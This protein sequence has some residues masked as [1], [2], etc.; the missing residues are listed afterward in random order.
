[1]AKKDKIKE[2][3][4]EKDND[5]ACETPC[6]NCDCKEETKEPN[7]LEMLQRLQAEFENYKKRNALLALKA[8]EEGLVKAVEAIL[9]VMD[10]FNIAAENANEEQQ[11]VL[12]VVKAQLM[13]SL[14]SLKVKK[15]DA[16]GQQ[17][18]PNLHNA[19]LTGSDENYEED[20]V[21]EVFQEGYTLEDKVIRYSVVKINKK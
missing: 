11:K 14:T 17:F 19:I 5:C 6:E 4:E 16:I 1:M 7:Y 3:L 12:T 15:I 10:T 9:P 21:L 18:N 2:M 8:K 20:E 13:N